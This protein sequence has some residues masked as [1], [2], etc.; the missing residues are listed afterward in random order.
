ME[1]LN[2]EN[3]IK[4]FNMVEMNI[5]LDGQTIADSMEQTKYWWFQSEQ[6]F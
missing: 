6:R 5:L 1:V 4:T 2:A 3:L